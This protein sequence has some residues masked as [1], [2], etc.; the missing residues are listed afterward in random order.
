MVD[1]IQVVAGIVYRENGDI[2]LTSRPKNKAYAGYWEFAGGK[3]EQGESAFSALQREFK[4]ELGIDIH[5]ARPWLQKRHIYEHAAVALQ[6]FRIEANDWKGE[7]QAREQQNWSWQRIGH[8]NV[9]PMLPANADLLAALMI[10]DDLTGNL[11]SGFYGKNRAN[12]DYR[13]VP[14][15]DAQ[16]TD[17]AILINPADLSEFKLL[18]KKHKIWL[19]ITDEHQ[20]SPI[21]DAVIW[22]VNNEMAANKLNDVL[23]QGLAIPVLVYAPYTLCEQFAAQWLALGAHGIIENK[24]ILMV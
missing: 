3:I 19:E 8:Y 18:N 24:E 23:Q 13:I 20:L 14:Y 4:E 10:P 2:L 11:T 1:F 22:R 5:V 21:A 9:T 6:F 15:R 17:Q 16:P 12:D 7:I